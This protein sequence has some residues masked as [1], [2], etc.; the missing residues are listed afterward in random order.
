MCTRTAKVLASLTD[1]DSQNWLNAQ[2]DWHSHSILGLELER[3]TY[4]GF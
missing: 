2:F 3:R 4:P 1:M